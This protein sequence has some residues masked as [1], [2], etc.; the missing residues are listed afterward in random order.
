VPSGVPAP[1]FV[2]GEDARPRRVWVFVWD[3]AHPW[4]VAAKRRA[5]DAAAEMPDWQALALMCRPGLEPGTT[6][7][8]GCS[9]GLSDILSGFRTSFGTLRQSWRVAAQL[10]CD[11][12]ASESDDLQALTRW[13]DPDS[14]RGHH[15]FRESQRNRVAHV[16]PANHTVPALD[17]PARFPSVS[18]GYP[19]VWDSAGASKSQ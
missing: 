13:R 3:L 19:C 4:R 16:R 14:N 2:L 17:P 11:M 8:S 7:S 5:V 15:D 6:T 12:S 18:L 9:A 1:W 10:V